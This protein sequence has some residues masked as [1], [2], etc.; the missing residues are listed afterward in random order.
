MNNLTPE[1]VITYLRR[2]G[3]KAPGPP[4]LATL[5]ALHVAHQQRLPFENLDIHLGRPIILNLSEIAGKVLNSGRGGYCYE[6]NTLFAA[7]LRSLGYG[8]ELLSARVMGPTGTPGPEF[9]HLALRV[10]SPEFS[11]AYLVDVGFGDAFLE[12][13]PLQNGFTR[14]QG[15]K[16][17]RLEQHGERWTYLEDRG[18]GV[19][20]QY[21]FTLTPRQLDEFKEMNHWQQTAPESHFTQ[22]RICS[23]ATLTGR[24]SL[25]G[26]RLIT[27]EHGV[28]HEQT[29]NDN[30]I[31]DVLN[32][33]FGVVTFL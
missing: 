24:I 27:T 1:Q 30:E 19:Q 22:N 2:L 32:Q 17:L 8:V 18:E 20:P 26:N 7:L 5:N 3:I 33:S 31:D 13:L 25:S 16:I 15:Q 21:D 9:D 12:P 4:T 29:L 11:G 23:I 6:L 10:T 28:R 14:Q